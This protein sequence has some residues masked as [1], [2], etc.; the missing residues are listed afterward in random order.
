MTDELQRGNQLVDGPHLTALKTGNGGQFARQDAVD[1]G[2]AMP[3]GTARSGLKDLRP[4]P[5]TVADLDHT[6]LISRHSDLMRPLPSSA[7]T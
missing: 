6:Q 4:N 7:R 5:A 3:F 1:Y 2:C